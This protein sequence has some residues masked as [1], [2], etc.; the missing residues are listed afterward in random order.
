VRILGRPGYT[1]ADNYDIEGGSAPIHDLASNDV[2][3]VHEM[4]GQIMGER[5]RTFLHHFESD[6]ED[7]STA[8]DVTDTQLND[9][10]CRILGISVTTDTIARMSGVQVSLESPDNAFGEFPLFVWSSAADQE[11]TFR[12]SQPGGSPSTEGY[13]STANA[14][15]MQANPSLAARAEADVMG[16]FVMRGDTSAFGAGTVKVHCMMLIARAERIPSAAGDPRN[17]GLPFPSW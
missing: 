4:G 13:L 17:F 7:Q 1:L 11:T 3:L 2:H 10:P 5:V 16:N 14:G 12:Y 15:C 8:F 6:D 9:V